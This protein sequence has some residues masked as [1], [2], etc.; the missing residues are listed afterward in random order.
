MSDAVSVRVI[1][2]PSR[3]NGRGRDARKPTHIPARGWKDILY[4]LKDEIADDRVGTVAAGT[5]FFLLLALFPALG[6]LVSLYGL[7]ADPAT[8]NQHVNDLR[9]YVPDAM[10]D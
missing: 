1:Q 7:V 5:T 8:I 2:H 6:A 10:L 4:R 3:E 9:G